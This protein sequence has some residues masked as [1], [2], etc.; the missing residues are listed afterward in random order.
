MHSFSLT[1]RHFV[2]A[3][4]GAAAAPWLAG[5]STPLPLTTPAPASADGAARLLASAQAHG[6]AA[7]RTLADI[8]FSYGGP[9]RPLVNR[10]QPEVEEAGYRG[11]AQDRPLPAQ[12]AVQYKP[13]LTE[14]T[15]PVM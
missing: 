9:W 12:A 13:P 4:A 8:N 6:L 3:V 2:G 15:W 7:C 5:C 1:R 10:V 11:A 14:M